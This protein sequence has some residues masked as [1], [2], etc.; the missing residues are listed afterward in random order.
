MKHRVVDRLANG[1]AVHHRLMGLFDLLLG[2]GKQFF[3]SSHFGFQ[4]LIAL[5][6]TLDLQKKKKKNKKK[7]KKKIKS[8]YSA[9]RVLGTYRTAK[10]L[11]EPHTK[12]HSC[13][14]LCFCWFPVPLVSFSRNWILLGR[15][16]LA[17]FP[18]LQCSFAVCVLYWRA[19][20]TGCGSSALIP[21]KMNILIKDL[22]KWI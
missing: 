20:A 4:M 5:L 9:R 15:V 14:L 17:K 16:A 10:N 18:S 21:I 19:S 3:Q 11:R 13:W 12:I 8:S 22:Y 2:E 6:Q 7:K 1:G